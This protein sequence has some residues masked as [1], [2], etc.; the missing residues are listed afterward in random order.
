MPP[1]NKKN[2]KSKSNNSRNGNRPIM[3][4]NNYSRPTT[5][6]GVKYLSNSN[7]NSSLQIPAD[8]FNQRRNNTSC[9]CYNRN[10]GSACTISGGKKRRRTKKKSRR[11]KRKN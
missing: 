6:T 11:T 8:F 3:M 2:N 1:K 5:Y 9:R 4:P 7:N 10:K